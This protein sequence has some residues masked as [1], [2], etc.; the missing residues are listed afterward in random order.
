M[1]KQLFGIK[2]DGVLVAKERIEKWTYTKYPP[3]SKYI[4]WKNI[5]FILLLIIIT[6][7]SNLGVVLIDK[8]I[9]IPFICCE[10]MFALMIGGAI[11]S[12]V[13]EWKSGKYWNNN[14]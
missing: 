6:I 10:F 9:T 12:T 14:E 5:K 1:I 8:D 7:I 3:K 13:T 11:W 2:N 4:L